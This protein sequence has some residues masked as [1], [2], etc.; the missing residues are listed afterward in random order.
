MVL[1][2]L[3][4]YVSIGL[5]WSLTTLYLASNEK[6][7][8]ELMEKTDK[9]SEKEV[10]HFYEQSKRMSESTGKTI[11][12]IILLILCWPYALYSSLRR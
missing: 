4:V 8:R 2:I 5:L 1:T 3:N 12:V 10:D 11:A 9:L 6:G 7:V